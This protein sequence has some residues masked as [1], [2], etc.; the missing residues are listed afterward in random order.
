MD[1]EIY[2]QRYGSHDGRRLQNT[3]DPPTFGEQGSHDCHGLANTEGPVAQA[4]NANG[5]AFLVQKLRQY[6][7]QKLS[8]N[9]RMGNHEPVTYNGIQNIHPY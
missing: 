3:F 9:L 4:I 8:D 1:A 2:P 6:I 5:I 7:L